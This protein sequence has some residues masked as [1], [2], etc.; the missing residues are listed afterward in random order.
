MHWLKKICLYSFTQSSGH[1]FENSYL[2]KNLQIYITS[3]YSNEYT[4][5]VCTYMINYIYTCKKVVHFYIDT[6]SLHK[7]THT[8]SICAYIYTRLIV[9]CLTFKKN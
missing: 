4:Q 1:A 3:K 9:S 6:Y 8:Q 2:H 5:T 7:Y